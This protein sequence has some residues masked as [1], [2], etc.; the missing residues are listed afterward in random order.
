MTPRRIAAMAA[1]A[2]F[3]AAWQTASARQPPA[4][5]PV[6]A[7]IKAEGMSRSHAPQLFYTLTED[8]KN[9][10][11]R[12]RHTNA[13]FADAVRADDLTQSATVLAAFAWQAASRDE[14]IPRR[15]QGSQ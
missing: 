3:S 11:T 12:T 6:V 1:M 7:A 10:D 5:A 13:D 15:P 4:Q 2:A 8:F 14:K 9:Y